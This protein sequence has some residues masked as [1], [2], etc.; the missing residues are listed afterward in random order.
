MGRHALTDPPGQWL[1]LLL[2]HNGHQGGQGKDHR[3]AR[4]APPGVT[5]LPRRGQAHGMG[6][7]GRRRQGDPRPSS[8]SRGWPQRDP[9]APAEHALRRS[10]GGFSCT[11]YRVTVGHGLPCAARITAGQWHESTPCEAIMEAVRLPQPRPCRVAGAQGDCSPRMRQWL[12]PHRFQAVIPQR[13]DQRQRERPV[14]GDQTAYRR[15]SVIT[16]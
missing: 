7:G 9:D 10:R 4:P 1:E 8:G 2:P 6:P 13:T 11:L 14:T 3:P 16:C 5:T 15:R 12:R